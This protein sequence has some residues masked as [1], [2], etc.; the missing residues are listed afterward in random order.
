MLIVAEIVHRII[1]FLVLIVIVKVILSYFMPPYAQVRQYLDRFV[2][3][4]LEPVRRFVPP[5]G[6]MDFSPMVL[7]FILIILDSIVTGLLRSLAF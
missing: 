4:I 1:Q 2:D 5:V 7:I 6:M 3:P